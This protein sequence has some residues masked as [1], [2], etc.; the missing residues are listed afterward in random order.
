MMSSLARVNNSSDA[1]LRMDEDN[2][3]QHQQV[4][5]F[6]GQTV[7]SPSEGNSKKIALDFFV[8]IDLCIQS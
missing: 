8:R 5:L 6:K 1:L 2:D 7:V 4:F 3:N